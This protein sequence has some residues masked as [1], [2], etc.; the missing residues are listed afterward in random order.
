MG[1]DVVWGGLQESRRRGN[2]RQY[3]KERWTLEDER[4]QWLHPGLNNNNGQQQAKEREYSIKHYIW[5]I[6][7]VQSPSPIWQRM[8]VQ[9]TITCYM[10]HVI[11]FYMRDPILMTVIDSRWLA[12]G[13]NVGRLKSREAVV[14]T[15]LINELFIYFTCLAW[16][17]CTRGGT[18]C[19]RDP[20][21][22]VFY[23]IKIF[24]ISNIVIRPY[25]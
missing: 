3:D 18:S 5:C 10:L 14:L 15:L 25:L 23:I 19:T 11:L 7:M 9:D 4:D 17:T 2:A 6:L 13:L 21:N 20:K 24:Q 8:R 12:L 22:S 16:F 1:G